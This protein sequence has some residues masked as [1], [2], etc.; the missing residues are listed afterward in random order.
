MAIIATSI[1]L[2]ALWVRCAACSML[3]PRCGEIYTAGCDGRIDRFQ[4][5]PRFG[6]QQ[7]TRIYTSNRMS[8]QCFCLLQRSPFHAEVPHKVWFAALPARINQRGFVKSLRSLLWACARIIYSVC[9]GPVLRP[10]GC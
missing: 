8:R 7:G 4:A 2:K 1:P 9:L 5:I 3:E 6:V 10:C